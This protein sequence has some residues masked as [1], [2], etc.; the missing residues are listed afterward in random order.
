MTQA[1][2]V[3]RLQT[4]MGDEIKHGD[5]TLTPQ[6]QYFQLKFPFGRIV[7]NRPT[8]VFVRKHDVTYRRPIVDVTRTAE[9]ILYGFS[10]LF[11][12]V[13]ILFMFSRKKVQNGE[14]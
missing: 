11:S 7:Y 4:K 2:D 10:A 12:I 9:I 1:K 6:S 8:A 3:V 5:V 14:V 13:G